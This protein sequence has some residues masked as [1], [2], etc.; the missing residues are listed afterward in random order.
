MSFLTAQ[1]QAQLAKTIVTN[2]TKQC[3]SCNKWYVQLHA[4]QFTCQ[5]IECMA[6][7]IESMATKCGDD[8]TNVAIGK[9]VMDDFS[10]PIKTCVAATRPPEDF[11][12]RYIQVGNVLCEMPKDKEPT[13][14]CN[15]EQKD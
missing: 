6:G 13:G 7:L 15:Y 2:W 3:P 14:S 4:D 8:N 11:N 10:H 5:R 1:A 12:P 9:Q